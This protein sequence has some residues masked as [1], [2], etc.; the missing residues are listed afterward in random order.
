MGSPTCRLPPALMPLAPG[1]ANLRAAETDSE[2]RKTKAAQVRITTMR[3]KAI[4]V[5]KAGE[6]RGM[7]WT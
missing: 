1:E 4:V 2:F 7:R 6:L 3:R 5:T